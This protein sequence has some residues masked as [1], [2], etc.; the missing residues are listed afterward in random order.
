TLAQLVSRLFDADSGSITLGGTELRDWPL[1]ALLDRVA[2]VFQHVHLFDGSVL[3]NLR[4]AN[5]DADLASVEAAARAACAH[6]FIE[7]LPQGY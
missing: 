5:P 6:D 1:H 7:R 3:D 4:M 2:T